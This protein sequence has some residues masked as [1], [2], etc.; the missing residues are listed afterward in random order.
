VKDNNLTREGIIDA[1]ESFNNVDLGINV[2]ITFTKTDHD[3]L[4]EVWPTIIRHQTF[5]PLDWED[6]KKQKTKGNKK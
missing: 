2:P 1:L 3:A 5:I 4:K 6:L